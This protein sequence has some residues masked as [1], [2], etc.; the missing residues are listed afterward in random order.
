MNIFKIFFIYYFKYEHTI[1]S[2]FTSEQPNIQKD[3]NLSQV[4]PVMV[5]QDLNPVLAGS[6]AHASPKPEVNTG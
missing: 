4:T 1:S 2:I 3:E 6:K 5:K